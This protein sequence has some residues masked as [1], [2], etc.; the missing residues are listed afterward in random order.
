[1]TVRRAPAL[2]AVGVELI[3]VIA[4]CPAVDDDMTI[5]IACRSQSHSGLLRMAVP[6]KREHH[7]ASEP[8]QRR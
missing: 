1:M 3:A 5:A 4:A 6:L 2:V 7:P 8:T